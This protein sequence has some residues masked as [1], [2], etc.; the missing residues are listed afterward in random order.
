MT[1]ILIF[2]PTYD[3]KDYCFEEFLDHLLK[4]KVNAQMSAVILDNTKITSS[5]FEKLCARL[6]NMSIL[7]VRY[8]PDESDTVRDIL[9]TSYN[10]ARN[11]VLRE[12]YDYL[13]TLESDILPE[14]DDLQKLL[15]VALK[16]EAD[17]VGSVN[18]YMIDEHDDRT[19]VFK[20]MAEAAPEPPWDSELN[21]RCGLRGREQTISMR[22]GRYG[23]RGWFIGSDQYKL[24]E[25]EGKTQP[26][27]VPFCA[28]GFTLISRRVLRN[29]PFRYRHDYYDN[30]DAYF[31]LD[32]SRFDAKVFVHPG[33]RPVHQFQPW[34][35]NI[36]R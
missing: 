16:E 17:I 36:R 19:L 13:L 8:P 20:S 29:V 30:P 31:F 7:V 32:V 2:T 33:V 4:F 14:P 27:E 23:V 24:S 11:I 3:V 18:G 34:P 1:K 35:R 21:L 10:I 26:F 28:L 5:Y 22:C 12:D 9:A 15:D 25:L 6:A